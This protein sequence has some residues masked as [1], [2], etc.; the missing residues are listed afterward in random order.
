[1][2]S[3]HRDLSYCP[4][5]IGQ[6]LQ[7][8]AFPAPKHDTESLHPLALSAL[9]SQVAWLVPAEVALRKSRGAWLYLLL[10]RLQRADDLQEGRLISSKKMQNSPV[11]T[12]PRATNRLHI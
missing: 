7:T 11:P 4:G 2:R 3:E 1:M 9:F 6:T 8:G 10:V 5:L 12:T